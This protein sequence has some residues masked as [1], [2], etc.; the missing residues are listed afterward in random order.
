MKSLKYFSMKVSDLYFIP[1]Q[2]SLQLAF[3]EAKPPPKTK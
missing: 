1:G 2:E 3:D